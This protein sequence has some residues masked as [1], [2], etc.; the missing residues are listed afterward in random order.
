M[1]QKPGLAYGSVGS[2]SSQHLA[3]AF[4]EQ[5][6]I[7]FARAA[8]HAAGRRRQAALAEPMA[9]TPGELGRHLASE[10]AKW[11]GIIT[12]AGGKINP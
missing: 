7:G 8:R 2:G 6:V 12:K 5:L 4:F 11:R 10:V 9:S 3:G 1:K